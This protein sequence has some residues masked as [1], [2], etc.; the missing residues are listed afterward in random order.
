M[1]FTMKI[2][3]IDYYNGPVENMADL[4]L[5]PDSLEEAE[6]LLDASS[7][8]MK[9]FNKSQT[10][11]IVQLRKVLYLE[12]CG[13]RRYDV[14]DR[15]RALIETRFKEKNKH[16]VFEMFESVGKSFT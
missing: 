2:G 1:S 6:Y 14:V 15:I 7:N 4:C 12:I 13:R 10:M 11:S 16:E 9:L 3:D 8:W 5:E